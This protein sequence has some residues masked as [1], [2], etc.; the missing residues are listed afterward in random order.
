MH[1]LIA[2]DSF[3]GSLSSTQVA[4]Y[5]RGPLEARGIS[6][7]S[8]PLADGGEGTV[9]ALTSAG[10]TRHSVQVMGPTGAEVVAHWA[11]RGPTAV[12]E[13]AQAS[14]LP[15][16]DPNPQ[17]AWEAT[18]F[19]TGEV[20]VDAVRAGC[21]D[22]VL[23]VGGSAT[24]DAGAGMLDA[25]EQSGLD[26]PGDV[27][28]TVACDVDNPLTGA[29]GAARVFGPQKG[30][31]PA[32][33]ERLEARLDEL[34]RKLDP[35]GRFRNLPGAGAAGGLG[36]AAM[37]VLGARRVSGADF[38]LDAVGFDAA[39][40]DADV[41]ITGEGRFDAQTLSGKG[42]ATVIA[43][44]RRLG[45]GLPVI[46]VCG[47]RALRLDELPADSGVRSIYALTDFAPLETCMARPGQVLGQLADHLPL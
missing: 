15:L 19:G 25:L 32:T 4:S 5:L 16:V 10:F 47:Q 31:D 14:G 22:V 24:T 11:R 38:V 44:A 33:V 43:R 28:F 34:A 2:V 30:A 9:D 17:T 42:P 21:T 1:V 29:R 8:L 7:T 23:G 6:V 27:S 46:V 37:A 45:G 13:M 36:F 40:R 20:I 35:A 18:T 3:K 26:L 41:V 39:L 12:V